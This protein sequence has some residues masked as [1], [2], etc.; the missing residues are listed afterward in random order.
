M[1]K[2]LNAKGEAVGLPDII[3]WW[4]EVYPADIFVQEPHEIIAVRGIFLQMC[5]K[6]PQLNKDVLRRNKG[7]LN[8]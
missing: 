7:G 8:G 5:R 6:Y 2:L 4:L 1:V 3:A